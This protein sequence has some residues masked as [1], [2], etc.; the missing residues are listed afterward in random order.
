MPIAHGLGDRQALA[1]EG[2]GLDP[3]LTPPSPFAREASPP[4]ETRVGGGKVFPARGVGGAT[5]SGGVGMDAAEIERK[6]CMIDGLVSI[7]ELDGW[8]GTAETRGYFKG[9]RHALD[10][11]RVRLQGRGQP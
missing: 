3:A 8:N 11:R 6:L 2:G 10:A 1:V 7:A 4:S 5:A 9:E